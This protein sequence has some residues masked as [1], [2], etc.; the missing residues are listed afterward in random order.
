MY[1]Y[2]L[3]V[4]TWLYYE[5]ICDQVRRPENWVEGLE[6]NTPL[7]N[8]TEYFLSRLHELP[9]TK[10]IRMKIETCILKDSLR[11]ILSPFDKDTEIYLKKFRDYMNDHIK[12][13]NLNAHDYQFHISLSYHLISLTSLEQNE[14]SQRLEIINDIIQKRNFVIDFDA[15]EFCCF[16]DMFHFETLSKINSLV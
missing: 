2:L 3:P 7:C 13:K 5:G 9:Q 1:C 14:L 11:F 16:N 8:V 12:I 10:V 15:V 4:F 6:L